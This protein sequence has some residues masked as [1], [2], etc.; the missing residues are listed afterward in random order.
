MTN[1]I[2][3]YWNSI[4]NT[5]TNARINTHRK[6]VFKS[7]LIIILPRREK[8]KKKQK[9]NKSQITFD[10]F[11]SEC[12]FYDLANSI[13]AWINIIT[14]STHKHKHRD[15]RMWHW[16]ALAI[17]TYL[18]S[19]MICRQNTKHIIKCTRCAIS[20]LSSLLLALSLSLPLVGSLV[21]AQKNSQLF[22]EKQQKYR[23]I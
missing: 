16:I 4:K 3:K 19:P 20:I 11:R 7:C 6:Y 22:K 2:Y 23:G 15:L 18:F 5:H 10:K 13:Q 8:K 12:A 17:S 9:M 14:L 21:S 1:W